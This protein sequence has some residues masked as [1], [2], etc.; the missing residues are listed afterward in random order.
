MPKRR[1]NLELR[2][3]EAPGVTPHLVVPD[4]VVLEIVTIKIIEFKSQIVTVEYKTLSGNHPKSNGNK[5]WLWGGTVVDWSHPNLGTKKLIPSN[6]EMGWVTMD[7]E[8]G[9]KSYT[10]GYSVT[11]EV[12]GICASTLLEIARPKLMLAPTSVT[13][14]IDTLDPDRL[15]IRYATLR[16]YRPQSAGNWLGLWKGDILPWDVQPPTAVAFPEDDANE[17]VAT[18]LATL[19]PRSTY[20]VVYFMADKENQTQNTSAAAILR[21]DTS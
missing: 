10:F 4:P 5:L 13:L 11:G 9:H 20:T 6:D 8:L 3:P 17:G 14:E 18:F 12:L 2:G 16:G 21:F 15:V 1:G 7:V 19:R